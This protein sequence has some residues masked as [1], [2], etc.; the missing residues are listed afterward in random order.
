MNLFAEYEPEVRSS[1][2]Y[3]VQLVVA[4]T[5]HIEGVARLIAERNN[6]KVGELISSLE[7][8]FERA[9]RDEIAFQMFVAVDDYTVVGYGKCQWLAASTIDGAHGLPDGWYLMGMIVDSNYR[10]QGIGRRLCEA[11]VRWIKQQADEAFY[12]VN[13]L[14]EVSIR[15]HKHLGFREISRSFGFPGLVFQG[16]QGGVLFKADFT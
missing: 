4:D 8:T 13:A 3:Q 5:S 12:Y 15:L 16:G 11:R 10:R 1:L 9:E 14:N 2:N 7:R 6:I